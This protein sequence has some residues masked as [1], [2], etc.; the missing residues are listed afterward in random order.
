MVQEQHVLDK[1]SGSVPLDI[2]VG[3]LEVSI[4]DPVEGMDAALEPTDLALGSAEAEV[5]PLRVQGQD[6]AE[7]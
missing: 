5:A 6:M 1:E 4:F 7:M 3:T 2:E